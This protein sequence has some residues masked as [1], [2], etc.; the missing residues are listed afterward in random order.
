MSTKRTR[1][2]FSLLVATAVVV[3]SCGGSNSDSSSSGNRQRNAALTKA[4]RQMRTKVNYFARAGQYNVAV[5]NENELILWGNPVND[6]NGV[7]APPVG[8]ARLAAITSSQGVAIDLNNEFRAWGSNAESLLNVPVGINMESMTSLFFD[9]GVVMAIDSDGKLWAWGPI[10]NDNPSASIPAEVQQANIVEAVTHNAQFNAALDNTGKVHVWGSWRG[11]PSVKEALANVTAKHITLRNMTLS[12]VTTDGTIVEAGHSPIGNGLFSG[13]NIE[14]IAGDMWGNFLAADTDGRLYLKLGNE[15]FTFLARDVDEYNSYL[16]EGAPK[17]ASIASGNAHF[18]VLFDDGEFWDF[19]Q[20]WEEGMQT[21]DYFFSSNSVS[22][23]AAGNYRSFA[24]GDDY[25]IS[26]FHVLP[27]GETAPPVEGDYLAV[28]AGWN[29]SIALRRNGSVVSWGDGPNNNEIPEG[30]NPA[31]QIGAGFGFSAIRDI[32]GQIS[33]WGT[34]YSSQGVTKDKPADFYNFDTMATGFQNIIARGR[35]GS[36][37][38]PAVHVWGDNSYGQADVP[39]DLDASMVEDITVGYDCAAAVMSDGSVKVWGQCQFGEKNVP[40]DKQFYKVTLSF[41]IAAGITWE[42]EVVMWGQRVADEFLT[43]PDNL[44]DIIEIS[45][46]RDHILAMDGSGGIYGWGP[47]GWGESNIPDSFKPLPVPDRF[48]ENY[49]DNL[50][51]EK[52]NFD[53]QT[54]GTKNPIPT[55]TIVDDNPIFVVKNGEV[56]SVTPSAPK[57]PQLESVTDAKQI[58]M[59][60]L[61]AALNP[62]TSSGKVVKVADAVKLLGLKK[63]TKV[64]FL[65]PAKVAAANA[66]VCSITK[67]AVTITGSGFCD[68]KVSYTDSKKKK[69]TKALTLVATP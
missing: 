11:V 48:D 40:A 14:H 3:S 34:F 41:G 62:V 24:I 51:G 53:A 37:D 16:Y 17:V 31:R 32:Y 58:S 47:E 65:V 1:G 46:G 6:V 69:R 52:E 25:T 56:V 36:S 63:V 26:N 54:E 67:T 30:L 13:V 61:P 23:I 60:S 12:V 49:D 29:H 39:A 21:P 18:T 10:W 50:P 8:M 7:L 64:A 38:E 57:I 27:Q 44:R 68:V 33:S 5:S 66:K 2:L 35:H 55:P 15:N 59:T 19:N 22:P 43:P 9:S 20:F 45:V 28:A 42:N 4:V